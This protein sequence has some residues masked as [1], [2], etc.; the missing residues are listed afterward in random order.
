GGQSA[1]RSVVRLAD[2]RT[3]FADS[4]AVGQVAVVGF[5]SDATFTSTRL[6]FSA[7][8][9]FQHVTWRHDPMANT[10]FWFDYRTGDHRWRRLPA[11]GRVPY[12]KD[13][14]GT[15]FQ[16]RIHLRTSDH[17]LTPKLLDGVTIRFRRW[18]SADGRAVAPTRATRP[19]RN[20]SA[21]TSP[22]P[23][24]SAT[25][26]GSGAG[27]GGGSGGGTGGG[28][29]S[30][31]GGGTGGGAA[32]VGAA[33]TTSAGLAATA[34]VVVATS[35]PASAA[36]TVSGIA[37]SPDASA[38]SGRLTGATAGEA[39]GGGGGIVGGD[40]T[41]ADRSWWLIV[42]A[43]LL[44]VLACAPALVATLWRRRLLRAGAPSRERDGWVSAPR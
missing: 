12:D 17:S 28:V 42:A 40:L 44:A 32:S 3:L 10:G 19:S 6:A 27:S 7:R 2:G 29:G 39:G 11:D 16:Y 14:F 30:G 1:V 43:A 34:P 33:A 24:P 15:T 36:Q 25:V 35:A 5:P 13:A 9:V 23:S 22:S 21:T 20:P 41:V 26:A 4:G 38:A 8:Q 18:V 31:T 37:I